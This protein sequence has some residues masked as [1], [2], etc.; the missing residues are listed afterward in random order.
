MRRRIANRL[1][2]LSEK[3]GI[4]VEELPEF[5]EC[6]AKGEGISKW[7]I[8]TDDEYCIE[9]LEAMDN[10]IMNWLIS[11]DAEFR[12]KCV[13]TAIAYILCRFCSESNINPVALVRQCEKNEVSKSS[14]HKEESE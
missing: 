10:L 1:Q 3:R 2:K 9:M 8:L 12:E 5:K 14:K 7:K 13:C 11:I 6:Q 4:P